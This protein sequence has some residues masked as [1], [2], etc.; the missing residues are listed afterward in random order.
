[1]SERKFRLRLRNLL[2]VIQVVENTGFE[3]GSLSVGN[4]FTA[5]NRKLVAIGLKQ[6]AVYFSRIM[7]E[8]VQLLSIVM[9]T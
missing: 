3:L 6:M 1:M 4:V 5:S 9:T 2:K 8:V 7:S